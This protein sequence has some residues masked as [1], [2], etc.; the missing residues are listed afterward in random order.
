MKTERINAKEI[1][2]TKKTHERET[3]K[4]KTMTD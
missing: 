1:M 3:H 4:F 2:K